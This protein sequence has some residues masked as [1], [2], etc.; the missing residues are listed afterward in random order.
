MVFYKV[1]KSINRGLVSARIF[2]GVTHYDTPEEK[3][4][5]I[6]YRTQRWVKPKLPNSKLFVFDSL[7]NAK[8]FT[9][10]RWEDSPRVKEYIYECEVKNPTV[11][12]R[13]CDFYGLGSFVKY[14]KGALICGTSSAPKGTYFADAV[15]LTKR[16]WTSK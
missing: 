2:N 4:Y 3:K 9:Q 8:K 16:V 15:K 14:W 10:D 5:C 11:A 12:N 7:E 13:I 1:V 6:N